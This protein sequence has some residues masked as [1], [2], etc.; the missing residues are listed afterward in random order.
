M[1]WLSA[2][3]KAGGHLSPTPRRC[4]TIERMHEGSL[5]DASGTRAKQLASVAAGPVA[6]ACSIPCVHDLL[7]CRLAVKDCIAALRWA[8]TI[9]EQKIARAKQSVRHATVAC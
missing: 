6:S 7:E 4:C 2:W 9:G 3:R 5:A 8:K 1:Q